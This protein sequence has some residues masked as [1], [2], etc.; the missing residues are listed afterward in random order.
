[1]YEPEP[2]IMIPWGDRYVEYVRADRADEMCD[3]FREVIRILEA[4]RYTAGLGRH[5]MDRLK[6]GR[7]SI[8][9]YGGEKA[10]V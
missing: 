3:A 2:R 10:D 1:M 5:Q 6:R 8:K 7:A 4:V 9:A